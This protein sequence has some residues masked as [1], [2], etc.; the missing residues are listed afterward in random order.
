M[1]PDKI[2][3][4]GRQLEALWEGGTLTGMSDSQLLLR[5]TDNRD[6]AE[7][8]FRELLERH[9]PMVMGVCRQIL[10]HPHD[11]DD[12]F[13][14][15]FLV[16]VRKARSIRA[17][18]SLAPWLYSVAWRTARRALANARRYRPAELEQ[19]E[20]VVGPVSTD[21]YQLD[22]RP[23]IYE[24]LSRLPDKYREPIVL[25]HLEGKTHEEV[26]RLLRWPVGT[27]SGRLSR[28]RQLLRSRL[29]RR[30]VAVSSA[31]LSARW[32]TGDPATVSLKLLESTV[33]TV[34]RFS[35]V[36]AVSTSVLSLS[37]GVLKTMFLSKVKTISLC[38]LIVGAV[39]GSVGVW[40]HWPSHGSKT[41]ARASAPATPQVQDKTGIPTPDAGPGG[42]PAQ[43]PGVPEALAAGS[44][45]DCCP[46]F[47]GGDRPD[48][49]P[50]TVAA[51]T[52]S[53]IVGYFHDST[54]PSR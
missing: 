36:Q 51:N 21:A 8:A 1:I 54:E 2:G 50:L 28:G 52:V 42:Q 34:Y 24:E 44:G 14:A 41:A 26:A 27:V 53:R 3:A 33:S 22:V 17:D 31:M 11:A 13:Q 49:C 45:P 40:A 39:S 25:C 19:M 47:G 37:Q 6:A 20:E 16:L 7:A 23:L 48:W 9:G 18:Q 10:R 35:A 30:G 38:V 46:V 4:A 15:T 43:A 5:F 32:L 12:A 29:E